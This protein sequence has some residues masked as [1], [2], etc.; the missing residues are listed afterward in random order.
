MLASSIKH[1]EFRHN[2]RGRKHDLLMQGI[3]A[4]C[5][6]II[7]TYRSYTIE[8]ISVYVRDNGKIQLLGMLHDVN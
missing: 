8:F 4:K 6:V 2:Q 7:S 5:I 1:L 3:R